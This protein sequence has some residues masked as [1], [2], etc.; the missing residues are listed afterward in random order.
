MVTNMKHVCIQFSTLYRHYYYYKF[1]PFL[2]KIHLPTKCSLCCDFII[3][4]CC[5]RFMVPRWLSMSSCV[6]NQFDVPV[7]PNPWKTCVFGLGFRIPGW[8]VTS[9][10]WFPKE[11]DSQSVSGL[12]HSSSPAFSLVTA[13][14]SSS[15]RLCL[16]KKPSYAENK[17]K[18]DF[19]QFPF[20]NSQ[21][22]FDPVRS[23]QK[24]P[25]HCPLVAWFNIAQRSHKRPVCVC[26]QT[27]PSTEP[28][29]VR[30]AVPGLL[31]SFPVWSRLGWR[32]PPAS[33]APGWS[34][35]KEHLTKC[36]RHILTLRILQRERWFLNLFRH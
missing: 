28:A 18:K 32:D 35:V 4:G 6:L 36:W 16:L 25:L 34:A 27:L 20:R 3:S 15:S 30:P 10:G 13:G 11:E 8:W 23:D 26:V 5:W 17:N 19:P 29:P 33:W 22:P 12:R 9:R 7:A 1:L 21:H 2:V 31:V 24:V 14:S